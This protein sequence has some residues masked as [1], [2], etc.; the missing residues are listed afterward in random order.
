MADMKI[1][2][3][4]SGIHMERFAREGAKIAAAKGIDCGKMCHD[5]AFKTQQEDLNGYPEAV[6]GAFQ[7]LAWDGTFNCHTEEHKDAGKPCAGFLMAK[8]Y[9]KDKFENNG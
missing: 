3:S 1:T 5:C 4:G 7:A 6:E 2:D 8:E 9:F